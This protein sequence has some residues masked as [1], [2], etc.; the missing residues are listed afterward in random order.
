MGVD[1]PFCLVFWDHGFAGG[2]GG[3]YVDCILDS[4]VSGTLASGHSSNLGTGGQRRDTCMLSGL[5]TRWFLLFHM[6]SAW[7]LIL[8]A[9]IRVVSHDLQL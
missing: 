3:G 5:H 7:M 2:R 6:L 9:Y 8:G 1:A 4:A